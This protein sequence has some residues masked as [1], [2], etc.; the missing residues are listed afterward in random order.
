[1]LPLTLLALL[2]LAFGE[3]R[4]QGAVGY[5]SYSPVVLLFVVRS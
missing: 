4:F 1:M 3:F 2:L 5:G